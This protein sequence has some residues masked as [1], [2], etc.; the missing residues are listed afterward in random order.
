MSSTSTA[1]T[2]MERSGIRIGSSHRD[3]S[4]VCARSAV[5]ADGIALDQ[6][7][8]DVGLGHLLDLRSQQ[9]TPTSFPQRVR[10][11][12]IQRHV[13]RRLISRTRG[14]CGG[15]GRNA[16]AGTRGPSEHAN[17]VARPRLPRAP[18]RRPARRRP[19]R[20]DEAR[21]FESA[22]RSGQ[23]TEQR[24]R[25]T[26]G[27]IGDDL[28]RS[29]R[30]AQVGGVGAHHRDASPGELLAQERDPLLVQLDG[31]DLRARAQ[32]LVRDRHRRPRPRRARDRQATPRPARPGAPPSAY[33]AGATPTAPVARARKT[34]TVVMPRV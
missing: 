24:S 8:K 12:R 5:G 16:L 22:R 19:R 15:G 33:R 28:E 29:A 7:G 6:L 25:R 9:R 2:A 3:R 11:A 21:A 32:Q 14:S 30:Q 18:S 10:I 34:I 4:G 17:V 27:W 20:H 23:P 1:T 26:E 13:G 31:D